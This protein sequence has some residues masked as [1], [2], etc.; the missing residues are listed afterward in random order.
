M[1]TAL[2]TLGRRIRARPLC[3]A[4]RILGLVRVRAPV[5][6]TLV[7]SAARGGDADF[8]MPKLIAYG[9]IST[10]KGVRDGRSN[11][12]ATFMVMSS[13]P[14]PPVGVAIDVSRCYS[15]LRFSFFSHILGAAKQQGACLLVS[16]V[17]SS[18]PTLTSH[19]V[20]RGDA[21][22]RGPALFWSSC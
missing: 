20:Q 15:F 18:W 13:C 6:S 12:A 22:L 1:T 11:P 8:A 3:E 10:V 17:V 4:L 2:P 16:P 19:V 21:R 14:R 5:A 9:L 7:M